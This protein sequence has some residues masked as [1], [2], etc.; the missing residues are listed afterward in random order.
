MANKL[1]DNAR[2]QF[3]RGNLDWV[4]ITGKA[5]MIDTTEYTLDAALHQHLDDIPSAARVATATLTGKTASGGGVA[6]ASDVTFTAVSGA[7]VGAL[8]IYEDSGD[9]ATSRLIAWIDSGG[10]L[11]ITPNGSDILIKWD[12]GPDKI[13]R[14]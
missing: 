14:L 3:L 6:D 7:E 9:E 4:N 13:F 8:A 12:D 1:Y 5:V 2:D 10:G 11:P